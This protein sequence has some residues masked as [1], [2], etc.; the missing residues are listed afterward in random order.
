VE[1]L[2][3]DALELGRDLLLQIG[4]VILTDPLPWLHRLI[5]LSGEHLHEEQ[6]IHSQH[7]WLLVQVIVKV[8]IAL[9]TELDLLQVDL[10][11]NI[12]HKNILE[13]N[14]LLQRKCGPV[15]DVSKR[16]QQL[17]SPVFKERLM[18]QKT[19]SSLLCH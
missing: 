8:I 3:D 2:V 13:R 16:V 15:S 5:V 12:R 17:F 19:F 6:R 9:I 4:Q 18:I 1:A 10:N 11:A 7:S 14:R